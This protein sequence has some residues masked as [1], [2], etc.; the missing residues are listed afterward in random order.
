MVR[1]RARG[2]DR[3]AV[4]TD[5]GA[6]TPFFDFSPRAAAPVLDVS[7]SRPASKLWHPQNRP[8]IESNGPIHNVPPTPR[9]M[10]PESTKIDPNFARVCPHW[11]KSCPVSLF[12][13]GPNSVRAS[14]M[15]RGLTSEKRCAPETQVFRQEWPFRLARLC[16]RAARAPSPACAARAPRAGMRWALPAR[17]ARRPGVARAR[18]RHAT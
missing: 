12:F 18:A 4:F 9:K 14:G 17:F 3:R 15:P 2:I 7:A 11:V 10:E 16:A 13:K 8:P 5:R 6:P 1:G